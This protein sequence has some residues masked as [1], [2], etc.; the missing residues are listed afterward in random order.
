MYFDS[1]GDHIHPLLKELVVELVTFRKHMTLIIL[2]EV[3]LF[4][5]QQ[6]MIDALVRQEIELKVKQTSACPRGD[7]HW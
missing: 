6:Q 1:Q 4:Q 2:Q 3:L 7:I 5:I